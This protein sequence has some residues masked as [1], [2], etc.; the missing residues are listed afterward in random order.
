[1]IRVLEIDSDTF[2]VCF[3]GRRRRVTRADLFPALQAAG[4]DLAELPYLELRLRYPGVYKFDRDLQLLLVEAH[5]YWSERIFMRFVAGCKIKGPLTHLK[6][7][8]EAATHHYVPAS[9]IRV[10]L[11]AAGCEIDSHDRITTRRRQE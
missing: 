10:L 4:V 6:V 5:R 9:R 7:A 11:Q 3:D 8:F 2:D 1:M